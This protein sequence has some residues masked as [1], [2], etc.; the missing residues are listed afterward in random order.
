MSTQATRHLGSTDS[1]RTTEAMGEGRGRMWNEF[2][3]VQYVY[4]Q[5]YASTTIH[6]KIY[7][8]KKCHESL[9]KWG[10]SKFCKLNFTKEALLQ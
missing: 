9:L 7:M 5:S 4:R 2:E 8:N 1:C 3:A 10:D 6:H